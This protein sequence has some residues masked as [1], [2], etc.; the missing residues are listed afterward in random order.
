MAL[1]LSVPTRTLTIGIFTYIGQGAGLAA[2]TGVRPFLPPL[3]AGGL[4]RADVAI[5]FEDGSFAF[6][7]SDWFLAV[8]FGLT[9]V[10]YVLGRVRPGGEQERLLLPLAAILGALLFAGL[11]ESGGYP[12]W[13]GA[14]G[15]GAVAALAA[16]MAGGLI[17]G[18]RARLDPGAA[19]LLT[20]WADLVALALA[21]GSALLWPLG[22]V[23]L[24]V[25]V[26]LAVRIRTGRDRKYE[27]LRTLR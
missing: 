12:F 24:V 7:E 20:V 27:G 21:A 5:D 25:L 16:L 9:V 17:K 22:F 4:A 1:S 3:L 23:A 13:I 26:V 6:L 19:A 10:W 2:A 15:G 11:L 8:V 18:A 14:V